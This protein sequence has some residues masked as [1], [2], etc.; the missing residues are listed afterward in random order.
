[1]PT[2]SPER[3]Y[4]SKRSISWAASSESHGEPRS[5]VPAGVSLVSLALHIIELFY[6]FFKGVRV[7]EGEERS[8]PRQHRPP[9]PLQRVCISQ[10]RPFQ[11]LLLASC[12]PLAQSPPGTGW[13]LET[14]NASCRHYSKQAS[15]RA[16]RG[17]LQ[18]R[19]KPTAGSTTISSS[20]AQPLASRRQPAF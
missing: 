4:P 3:L 11:W 19:A 9:Q 17:Q 18:C 5:H 13:L 20:H 6:V 15:E 12:P 7:C 14:N 16:K 1:M 10:I 8:L 2:G